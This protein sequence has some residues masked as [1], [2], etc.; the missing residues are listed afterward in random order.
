MTL[1]EI[2]QRITELVDPETGELLDF[3]AFQALQM[4]RQEKIENAV[5]WY[6]DLIAQAKAIKEEVE[7]L[8]KRSSSIQRRAEG[9]R[10]WIALA[11]NGAKFS[12]P[13][14]TV[15]YRTSKSLEVEDTKQTA[16]WLEDNGFVDLVVHSD[17][18]L[19]K[20]AVTSLVQQGI[21]VPGAKIV[22]RKCVQVR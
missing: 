13:R 22:E 21:D 5:L 10:G 16:Q 7:N 2:D 9:V 4:D 11:L 6:K 17:P 15:T 8:T 14:C 3:D 20:R 1:Y 18:K 12:T 19:D